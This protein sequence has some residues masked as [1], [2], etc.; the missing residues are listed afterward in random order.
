MYT[1]KKPN[2]TTVEIK[3]SADKKEWEEA[4]KRVYERTKGKYAV[5]GF[6]KGHV[7]QKV[8]EKTYGDGVFFED[9]FAD[10]AEDAYRKVLAED[11]NIRPYGEPSL[12]LD[13]FIE[14]K[15]EGTLTITVIPPV[16]L[17]KYTG[18]EVKAHLAEFNEDMVEH[19]LKHAQE[20]NVKLIDKKGESAMGDV[21]TIDFKGSIDGVAFDGGTAQD[22]D[23]HLGSKTFID[24]FEDQLVGKKAG[25]KV[26]VRVTFPKN[27]NAQNL[28]GK[29]AL[30]ECVVKAVKSRKLPKIDDAL[31]KEVADIDTLED[32]KKDIR[33]AIIKDIE[34]R[35]KNISEDAIL[36]A[37]VQNSEVELPEALVEQQLQD[38]MQD[39]SYRLSYQGISLEDYAKYSGTTVQQIREERRKD[40]LR[41]AKMRQVLE[42]I[43]RTEKLT[44]EDKELDA[45][46]A[47]FA[48]MAN[49]SLQEYK[50]T[51]DPQRIDYMYSDILMSKVMNIL[52]T[53]NTIVNKCECGEDCECHNHDHECEC[54]EDCECHKEKK[55]TKKATAPKKT[56]AKKTTTKTTK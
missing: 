10:L 6:R 56:T 53:K 23:L 45:K 54:G 37:I 33:E 36:D 15:L 28:A 44:V 22:Y 38:V 47:E 30:F 1:V 48:K 19:E 49:K 7:P 16:K 21:V 18:L 5:Q 55:T 41:I 52:T 2:N 50:K 17:G 46:L 51:I 25:D 29:P 27:Y 35:N 32:W 39:L 42:A 3:I 34:R 24:N 13:K 31:A 11:E 26:D 8:I 9:A 14:G 20:E 43:V 12:K 40:A 4:V